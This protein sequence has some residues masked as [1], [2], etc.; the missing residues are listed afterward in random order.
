MQNDVVKT[1]STQSAH[2]NAT[3]PAFARETVAPPVD[4]FENAEELLVV[5]DL[6]GVDPENVSLKFADNV[7]TL[8]GSRGE[9]HFERAL[10]IRTQIDGDKIHAESKNGTLSVHLPKSEKAKPRKIPV[11]LG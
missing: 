11:R 1:N 4:V 6:P 2:Q 10:A 9:Q 5:V 8:S 7:L 3:K